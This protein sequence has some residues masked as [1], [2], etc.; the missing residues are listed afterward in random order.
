MNHQEA[1]I[2]HRRMTVSVPPELYAA[3]H[4]AAE[5]ENRSASA[6]TRLA[7]KAYLET[8]ETEPTA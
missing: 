2:V 5:T 6:V 8:E 4:T 1:P 3:V 7:L